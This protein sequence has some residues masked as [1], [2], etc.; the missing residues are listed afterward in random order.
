LANGRFA[1]RPRIILHS[2]VHLASC[3]G[4]IGS[5]AAP[6]ASELSWRRPSFGAVGARVLTLSYRCGCHERSESE[7]DV[8][9]A[10]DFL[11]VGDERAMVTLLK[12][13]SQCPLM[14][15][16]GMR[17]VVNAI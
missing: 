2:G 12:H 7:G 13:R 1:C 16:C 17:R 5:V 6:G 15:V 3:R 14:L 9:R 4:I 11:L 8:R 10:R